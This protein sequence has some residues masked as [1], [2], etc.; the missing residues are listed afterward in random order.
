[1]VWEGRGVNT[2]ASYGTAHIARDTSPMGFVLMLTKLVGL[3]GPTAVE[4]ARFDS[5][6]VG[7]C[8]TQN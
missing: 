3:S 5:M 7:A 4:A 1:M 8:H 6:S 2:L